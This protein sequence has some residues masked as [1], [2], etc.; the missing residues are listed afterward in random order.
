MSDSFSFAGETYYFTPATG[1]EKFFYQSFI[2]SLPG[3]L[4]T[5]VTLSPF[6]TL[7]LGTWYVWSMA[8]E[9]F[10]SIVGELNT[11]WYSLLITTIYIFRNGF[12]S[13]GSGGH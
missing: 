1:Y 8:F 4:I 3:A 2:Y 11:A 12:D 10:A 9:M 6:L 7:W 13:L 5:G